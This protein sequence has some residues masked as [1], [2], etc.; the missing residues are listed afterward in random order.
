[1]T[2]LAYQTGVTYPG[3]VDVDRKELARVFRE[4]RFH[5]SVR[6]L[7]AFDRHRALA[8]VAARIGPQRRDGIRLSPLTLPDG[9]HVVDFQVERIVQH[10]RGRVEILPGARVYT[11]T[12][13]L[14]VTGPPLGQEIEDCLAFAADLAKKTERLVTHADVG[15]VSRAVT[16][17]LEEAASF[18]FIAK[19]THVLLAGTPTTKRVIGCLRLIRERF[20]DEA[21]RT[22]LRAR[23]VEI[24]NTKENLAAIVDAVIDDA[25]RRVAEV[26]AQLETDTV[27]PPAEKETLE[28]HRTDAAAVLPVLRGQS[29]IP[30]S[31][32]H[33]LERLVHGV[34]DSYDSAIR[35]FAR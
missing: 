15:Y 12:E 28:K 16:Y 23:V 24:T 13:G 30:S 8:A 17:M 5:R 4:F 20:Y 27:T 29:Y 10:W 2:V 25:E 9:D 18:R 19:G 1:M 32:Q 33:R 14:F 22:G 11:T 35:S 3:F 31:T 26:I 21:S 7:T 6:R 34:V